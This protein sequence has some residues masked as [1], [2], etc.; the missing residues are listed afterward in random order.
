MLKHD[1]PYPLS[2]NCFIHYLYI[3]AWHHSLSSMFGK[4]SK[5]FAECIEQIYKSGSSSRKYNVIS[6]FKDGYWIIG[7]EIGISNRLRNLYPL[8]AI[9]S[10]KFGINCI[11]ENIALT[12][13]K[14]LKKMPVG[15]INRHW[16]Y[17]KNS[18]TCNV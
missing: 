2:Q 16:N 9:S 14:E 5:Q 4:A 7:V 11:A 1:V 8:L 10:Q 15:R 17:S 12:I 13:E 6:A 18:V 3:D